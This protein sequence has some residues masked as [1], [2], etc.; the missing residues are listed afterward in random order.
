LS[1]LDGVL[2]V[3]KPRGPTSHDV[4]ARVRRWVKPSRV[5][6][7]GTLDPAATG[8]LV[9]CIGASTRLARFLAADTKH[10]EGE[11]VLGASTDTYDA[12]GRILDQRPFDGI[13]L[14]R[15]KS[16]AA[17]LTGRLA[18]V[19][20]LWSAKRVGG[21]RAYEM[22]RA[23]ESPALPAVPVQ[24]DRFD[25]EALG[26][27]RA[28][29]QVECSA[30]TYVRSLAHDLGQLLGCGAHL[31]SLRRVRSGPFDLSGALTLEGV[32]KAGEERRLGEHVRSLDL[33]GLGMPAVRLT[34]EGAR[35]ASS[36]SR[37]PPGQMTGP[38]TAGPGGMIRLISP[39]G[40]LL[41]IAEPVE[42]LQ[43]TLQPRIVLNRK[44]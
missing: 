36:G 26:D 44:P 42:G 11:I 39:E 30:G 5:G 41:A 15:V 38:A 37:I 20:P 16:A 25:I 21:R 24:V 22:A 1:G 27:G 9:V 14:D 31:A 17:S 43:G 3:D 34:P 35:S 18:Q 7:T 8:V 40:R 23:G 28:R 13:D 19:P 2:V 33:L 32:E 12:E 4:V 10:Y 29:F 6:H